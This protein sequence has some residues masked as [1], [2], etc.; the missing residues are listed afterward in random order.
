MGRV[1]ICQGMAGQ[2]L[3]AGPTS[4]RLALMPAAWHKMGSWASEKIL[5]PRE[6]LDEYARGYRLNHRAKSVAL[7]EGRAA[8]L[9]RILGN[10]LPADLTEARL[11]DHIAKRQAE[12]ASGRT[13][14][15]ELRVLSRALGSTWKALWPRLRKLEERRDAGRHGASSIEVCALVRDDQAGMVCLSGIEP[16]QAG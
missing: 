4:G 10:L 1:G 7:V 12:G 2:A 15:L 8:H 11:L 3:S 9:K 6:L 16:A 5:P 13:I 14:N